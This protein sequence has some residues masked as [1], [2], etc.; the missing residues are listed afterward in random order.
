MI[1][2][3]GARAPDLVEHL[4]ESPRH[5]DRAG[6]VDSLRNLDRARLIAEPLQDLA[7]PRATCTPMRSE[8][9]KP[10]DSPRPRCEARGRSQ[11]TRDDADAKRGK[12]ASR[13]ATTQM[14]SEEESWQTRDN[15]DAKRGVSSSQEHPGPPRPNRGARE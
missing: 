2:A 8:G 11:Q 10:A 13:L 6:K 9:R 5:M 12:E 1:L 3:A 7:E 14:Q 4:A 15:A